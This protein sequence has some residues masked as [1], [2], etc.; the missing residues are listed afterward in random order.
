MVMEDFLSVIKYSLDPD[1]CVWGNSNRFDL[2]LLEPYI[3]TISEE[4]PWKFRNERDV[5]TL[6][7]FNPD[8]KGEVIEQARKDGLDLHNPIVDCKLQIEYCHKIYKSL[9]YNLFNS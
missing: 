7:S 4:L 6:V 2:G 3:K 9:R 5:R 8:I 1:I